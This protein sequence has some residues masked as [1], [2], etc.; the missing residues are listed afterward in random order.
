MFENPLWALS[1]VQLLPRSAIEDV[2]GAVIGDARIAVAN[3]L[4]AARLGE[5][6]MMYV[7]YLHFL[8]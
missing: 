2:L 3:T 6:L 7:C 4:T 8:S 1:T 5:N